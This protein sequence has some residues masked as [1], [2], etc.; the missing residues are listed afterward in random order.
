MWAVDAQQHAAAGTC[1]VS[2][3]DSLVA[4]HGLLAW[5]TDSGEGEGGGER[6]G[7]RCEGDGDGDGDGDGGAGGGQ[8]RSVMG[9]SRR[10]LMAACHR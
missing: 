2:G 1:I 4:G 6:G 5:I 7:R 8:A 3:S 9:K 10:Q